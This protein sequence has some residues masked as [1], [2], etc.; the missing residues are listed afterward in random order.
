MYSTFICINIA[1]FK[2][3]ITLAV[4]FRSAVP[5]LFNTINNKLGI[6]VNNLSKKLVKK[7]KKN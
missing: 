3:N 4:S 5:K 1:A 2:Y 7:T 6:I